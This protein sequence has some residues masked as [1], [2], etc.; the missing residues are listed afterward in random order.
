MYKKAQNVP[1][2]TETVFQPIIRCLLELKKILM[3]LNLNYDEKL[4]PLTHIYM[5]A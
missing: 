4:I 2:I 5:T 3:N 1:F